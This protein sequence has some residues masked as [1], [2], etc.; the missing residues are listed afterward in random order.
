MWQHFIHEIRDIVRRMGIVF[1]HIRRTQNGE[2]DR[3]AMW[4]REQSEVF[5]DNRLLDW[6]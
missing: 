2:A 5:K 6:S 4:G 3:L 1:P